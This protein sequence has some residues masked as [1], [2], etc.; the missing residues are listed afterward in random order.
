[1]SNAVAIRAGRGVAPGRS[2]ARARRMSRFA[3]FC[4]AAAMAAAAL[5]LL[6]RF[7][8]L[9]LLTIRHVL[10]QGDSPLSRE[11]TLRLAGLRSVE[12]WHTVSCVA[13]QKRLEADPL[14]RRARVERIFPGTLRMTVDRR[15]PVALVLGEAGGRS[16]PLL[17][18]GDGY[19]FKIGAT[20]AEIE[21]PVVSGI[22]AGELGLGAGLPR[23]YAAL[24]AELASLRDSSPSLAA[25][26]SEVRVEQVGTT[27]LD[28]VLY[29][30]SSPVPV[31]AQG[32]IDKAFMTST[33]MVL[34][35]LSKQ[36]I[37]HDIQG[38]DFRGGQVV[39]RMKEG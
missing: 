27:G 36:G 19:L 32:P 21:L 35:L 39:Y 7:A 8:A 10:L 9:P 3:R 16:V 15:L 13:I 24:F 18:D 30:T 20:A 11:E 12:Y 34:D 17:V 33:L 6:A 4:L 31:R 25:L 29:L 26:L 1:M 37:L 14:V 22:S 28:L 2:P 5:F 23:A 38:L